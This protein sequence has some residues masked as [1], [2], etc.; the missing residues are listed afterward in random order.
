MAFALQKLTG[1]DRE[2]VLAAVEP[3]LAAHR[4]EGV[5]LLWRTGQGGWV[6]E[7]TLEVPGSRTPGHGVTLDLCSEISRDLGAAL[8][9][10]DCMPGAYRLEVGSPGLDRKLYSLADCARFEGQLARV[11]LLAPRDGE[12]VLRGQLVGVDDAGRALIE[13]ERGRQAFAWEE[14]KGA[15][16]VF[17]LRTGVKPGQHRA[18]SGGKSARQQRSR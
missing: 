14:V 13:T 4:V 15:Q 7:L 9:V 2:K 5:E 18:Q 3:V 16:L 11:Q 6:L 12:H 1:L 17:E 8:D 10:A